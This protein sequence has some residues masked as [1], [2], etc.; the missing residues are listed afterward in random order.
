MLGLGSL[1]TELPSVEGQRNAFQ[2]GLRRKKTLFQK[3]VNKIENGC[4]RIYQMEMVLGM[5]ATELL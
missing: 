4:E 1:Y 2:I 5:S 3:L